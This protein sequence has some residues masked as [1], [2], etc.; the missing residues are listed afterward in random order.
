MKK[1]YCNTIGHGEINLIFLSGWGFSS[2]IW[3]FIIKKIHLL[4]KCYL[5][6]LPGI[7]INQQLNYIN[8]QKMI[9]ILKKNI[10]KKSI[11]IGWSIG[12]L[13]AIYLTIFYPKNILG[14]I[15]V[16][17]SPCFLKKKKWPGMEKNTIH[18]FYYQLKNNYYKTINNFLCLQ[19]I[20]S[21]KYIQDVIKL[22]KIFLCEKKPNEKILKVGRKILENIDLR[23]EGMH[24]KTPLLRIY[25]ELDHLVPQKISQILDIQWPNSKSE[26]I[27]KARHIPFVSHKE[28]FFIILLKFIKNFNI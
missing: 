21:E 5:I 25:G 14:I 8:F 10:P 4:Y 16:C 17:S 15:N 22:K 3:F 18:H 26:I 1:F 12:G 27:K 13:I 2:K 28:E 9:N 19:T 23:Y 7:G 6:D 11:L 20:G 24:L